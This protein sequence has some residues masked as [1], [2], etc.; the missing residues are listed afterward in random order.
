MAFGTDSSWERYEAIRE[1]VRILLRAH[2]QKIAQLKK[3]DKKLIENRVKIIREIEEQLNKIEIAL[4]L[5]ITK[6]ADL[7]YEAAKKRIISTKS[8]IESKILALSINK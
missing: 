7:S 3:Y 8:V 2:D 5:A 1:T 6:K 4:S